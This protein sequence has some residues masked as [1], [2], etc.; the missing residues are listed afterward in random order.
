MEINLKHIQKMS[1]TPPIRALPSTSVKSEFE[2]SQFAILE[3]QA[4]RVW[5]RTSDE[6]VYRIIIAHSVTDYKQKL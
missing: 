6:F 3:L 1:Y 2:R 4:T 5:H